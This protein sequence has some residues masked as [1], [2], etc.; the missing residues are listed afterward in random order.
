MLTI[1]R[2]CLLAAAV[3]A[4]IAPRVVHAD[5]KES[6]AEGDKAY[7]EGRLP[8]AAKAYD[9]AIREAPQQVSADAY[10][11]RASIFYLQAAAAT[12]A[13][14][15]DEAKA[16]LEAG[17]DFIGKKAEAVYPDAPE[18][19]AQKALILWDLKNKPDAIKAAE[20]ATAKNPHIY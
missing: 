19:Q 20:A 15:A 3:A 2:T 11:K 12:R 17:L 14:K 1:T 18:I 16:K 7:D 5:V 8:K 9:S 6:L 4:V 10:G 13:G